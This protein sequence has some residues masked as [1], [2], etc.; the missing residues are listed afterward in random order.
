MNQ[1][2]KNIGI[3]ARAIKSDG[4]W[5]SFVETPTF[6]RHLFKLLNDDEYRNLQTAL[7]EQ[8]PD[9]GPVIKKTGGDRKL[10]W[11]TKGKGKS[12]GARVIYCLFDS[13]P[14]EL[15]TCFLLLIY[16]KGEKDSLTDSQKA[17]LKQ[18]IKELKATAQAT[19]E[20]ARANR[21]S[22]NQ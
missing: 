10:R 13:Q 15:R 8:R 22:H 4:S 3:A 16:P 11:A 2:V 6:T 1:R 21:T 18:A 20:S 7:V 5:M 12:G 19:F 9:A 14:P 17:A